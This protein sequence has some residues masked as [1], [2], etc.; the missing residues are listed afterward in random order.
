MT[1]NQL[2]PS[3]SESEYAAAFAAYRT[4]TNQAELML[5]WLQKHAEFIVNEKEEL[6]VLS[7]GTGY[8]E[9]DLAAIPILQ[10]LAP[11]LHYTAIDPNNG[12]LEHFK[13]DFVARRI[14]NVELNVQ[15]CSFEEFVR[16][17]P[18]QYD[19]IHFTHC[20]YFIS[21]RASAIKKSLELLK[22]NG[23]IL[24]FNSMTAGSQDLRIRFTKKA[25]G[26]L[27]LVF[28]AEQLKELLEHEN[29]K[30]LFDVIN[31]VTD[32]TECFT[33]RPTGRLLLN[34]FLLCNSD[35]ISKSLRSEVLD[36]IKRIAF[37]EGSRFLMLHPVGVFCISA[38]K[39]PV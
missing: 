5:E 4:K 28:S 37:A 21:D 20:L 17:E 24:I 27:S 18:K 7:V 6:S 26:K 11:R 35:N 36:Y 29:I 12:M 22:P 13:T 16:Q 3:L 1:Q 9:F 30:H 14:Q 2:A 33:S 8:G 19:L 10:K 23:L 32:V 34:F 39:S 38:Q 25:T 31:S 15:N